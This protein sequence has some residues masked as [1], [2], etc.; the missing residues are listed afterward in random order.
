MDPRPTFQHSV[1]WVYTVLP[2]VILNIAAILIFGSYYALQA[3]KPD[4]VSSIQPDQVQFLAY[5]VI[6]VVEWA[7]AIVLL[8]QQAARGRSL[9]SIMAPDGQI[10]R[11]K[12]LPALA[13]FTV[14]NLLFIIYVPLVSTIYG[15]WPRL[16][17]LAVWQR[18][19]IVLAVPIQAA[20]CEELIWRGHIIPGLKSRGRTNFA[21]VLL[22]ALSFALIHGIFLIDKLVLTFVLGLL[23][24]FYYLRERNLLPL[25]ISHFIADLWTFA[26][27]AL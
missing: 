5:A 21:A 13:L 14:F 9:V 2:A 8:R 12:W 25:M 26:L 7:F 24:G 20:F 3:T 19:F 27:S 23:T 18:A 17:H 15:G 16:N 10:L 22:A 1:L 11:F 4:L 6:F